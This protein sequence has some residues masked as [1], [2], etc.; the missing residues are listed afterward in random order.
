MVEG[1]LRMIGLI[2]RL[3]PQLACNL[4]RTQKPPALVL[5]VHTLGAIVTLPQCIWPRKCCIHTH[6]QPSPRIKK[7]DLFC[8]PAVCNYRARSGKSSWLPYF[9]FHYFL[10]VLL[11]RSWPGLPFLGLHKR[12]LM[13]SR[14]IPVY[15]HLAPGVGRCWH[16]PWSFHYWHAASRYSIITFPVISNIACAV[17]CWKLYKTSYR[18]SFTEVSYNQ[19]VCTYGGSNIWID[20]FYLYRNKA[21][22]KLFPTLSASEMKRN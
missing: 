13:H 14:I 20:T 10:P 7:G 16:R 6:K 11:L 18:C 4:L 17:R 21:E 22:Q 15:Y 19:E 1:I 3:I 5:A 2:I 12:G 8:I 9:C